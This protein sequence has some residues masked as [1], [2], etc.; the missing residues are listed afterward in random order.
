MEEESNKKIN[1]LDITISE[2]ENNISFNTYR[3]TTTTDI[4]IPSDTCHPL[5]HKFAAMSYLTNRLKTHTLNDT[6]IE[7]EK[8][9]Q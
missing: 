2:E 3:K 4:I 6:D 7:K 1:F 5:E 8:K 9:T